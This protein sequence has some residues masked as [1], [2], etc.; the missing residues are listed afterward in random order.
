[1]KPKKYF[2]VDLEWRKPLF[3][4][5]GILTSLVIVLAVFEL[6]GSSEK[7][8][9]DFSYEGINIIDDETVIIT[10]PEIEL[11]PPPAPENISTSDF[12]LVEDNIP[13][14][15]DYS[16]DAQSD[17]SMKTQE[18]EYVEYV[19]EEDAKEPEVFRFVEEDPEFPGGEKARQQ[20]FA[21]NIVYPRVA[22]EIGAEGRVMVSFIVEPDGK[23]TNVK[24]ERGR[25]QALD[26]EAVRVTKMMP[27]WKPGKQRGRAVR[28]QFTMPVVFML[29]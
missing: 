17:E 3:F 25:I 5:I 7:E 21:D 8:V 6:F 11:P 14:D 27:P 29:Q 1:M 22:R 18:I 10:K 9:A 15:I 26:E 24:I 12:K 28:C 20:F 4:Q 23:I 19:E 13:V 16:F 2:K